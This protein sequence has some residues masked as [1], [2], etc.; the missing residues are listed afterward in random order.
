MSV[1]VV[2]ASEFWPQNTPVD[3]WPG[4]GCLSVLLSECIGSDPLSLRKW[5]AEGNAARLWM[6]G[7]FLRKQ[8]I[9]LILNLQK[10]SQKLT[11]NSHIFFN[12]IYPLLT[13]SPFCFVDLSIYIYIC[14]HIILN[15]PFESKLK[16]LCMPLILNAQCVFLMNKEI[17]LHTHWAV[18][19]NRKQYW[20]NPIIKFTVCFQMSSSIP[21][22]PFM[23]I[24]SL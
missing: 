2:A 18:I 6:L 11:R 4:S 3:S 23:V 17:L 15:K 7:L 13:L 10:I 1:N 22:M 12:Q 16:T 5:E 9:D 21:T 19:K 14:V 20:N 8:R 24:F